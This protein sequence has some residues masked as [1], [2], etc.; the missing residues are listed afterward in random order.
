[1]RKAGVLG[2][3]R[4]LLDHSV[5]AGLCEQARKSLAQPAIRAA[6]VAFLKLTG[7]G[8]DIRGRAR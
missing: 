6:R 2:L 8:D 1:M 5:D 7:R 4:P 3:H